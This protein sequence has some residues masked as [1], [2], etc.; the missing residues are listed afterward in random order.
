[1]RDSHVGAMGVAAIVGLLLAKFA[2]L[3]SLASL[4]R[5]AWSRPPSSC[6]W[7]AAARWSFTWGVCPM[8]VPP[9]WQASSTGGGSGPGPP[10][11]RRSWRG[12]RGGAGNRG[13]GRLG[14]LD[15]RNPALGPLRVSQDRR[16]HGRYA[17]RGL[18]ADRDRAAARPGPLAP[19]T[20]EVNHG[21]V[22]RR[23][24]AGPGGAPGGIARKSS[25]SARASIRWDRPNCCGR[26]SAGTWTSCPSIPIPTA[27]NWSQPS[28]RDAGRAAAGVGGQWIERDPVGLGP[29]LPVFPRRG[30]GALLSANMPPWSA[31][32]RNICEAALAEISVFPGL[33]GPGSGTRPGEQGD[34]PLRPACNFGEGDRTGRKMAPAETCRAR[35]LLGSRTI[36]PADFDPAVY[37]ARHPDALFV[38]DEAFA[39]FVEGYRSLARRNTARQ[40]D[41]CPLA[42]EFYAMPVCGWVSGRVAGIGR[43]DPRGRSPPGRSTRWPRR[44]APRRLADEDYA[45]RSVEYVARQRQC[46]PP[47]ISATLACTSIPTVRLLWCG[48][49]RD[50]LDPAAHV[51]RKAA[52]TSGLPSARSTVASILT[53]GSSAWPSA[54]EEK[55]S[56]VVALRRGS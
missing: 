48:S 13:A 34:R 27:R 1:M 49:M 31:A 53:S 28:R 42:D 16:R 39:D 4:R 2:A 35:L 21:P 6:P 41:R 5:P 50:D 14:H 51:A 36:V 52:E 7:P 20:G 43:A 11:P 24:S 8:H 33:G 56:A 17:G 18:R 29:G 10:G 15:R 25:I 55:T 19:G 9:G 12:L 45:R 32:G 3:A 23:Q 47:R 30:S 40:R 22:P 26:S 46:W 38:V 54:P 37:V 44:W